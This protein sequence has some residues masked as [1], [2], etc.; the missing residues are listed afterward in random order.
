MPIRR[1][2]ADRARFAPSGPAD[3]EAQAAGALL[4]SMNPSQLLP[5][6]VAKRAAIAARFLFEAAGDPTGNKEFDLHILAYG[7]VGRFF[8][9]V[10]ASCGDLP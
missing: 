1:A 7:D 10:R 9:I 3:I 5:L 6:I 8:N 4:D 2:H